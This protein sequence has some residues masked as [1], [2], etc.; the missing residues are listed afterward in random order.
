[1]Q[2]ERLNDDRDHLF[3][4]TSPLL[5]LTDSRFRSNARDPGIKSAVHCSDR[6]AAPDQGEGSSK[7]SLSLE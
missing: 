1:M 7:C 2:Y 4:G 5:P 6:R 3:A